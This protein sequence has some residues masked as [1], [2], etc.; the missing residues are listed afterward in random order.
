MDR[1]VKLYEL[2][3][4]LQTHA[5]NGHSLSNLKVKI[6]DN[7]FYIKSFTLCNNN[8]NKNNDESSEQKTL[9]VLEPLQ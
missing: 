7:E 2:S 1:S 5:H 4:A 6:K 9:L 8:I 3:T